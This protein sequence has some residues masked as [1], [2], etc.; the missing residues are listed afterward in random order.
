MATKTSK[1]T[2]ASKA[3]SVS[4]K[5]SENEKMNEANSKPTTP[6]SVTKSVTKSVKKPVKKAAPKTTK[7]AAPKTTEN[8][9]KS[10]AEKTEVT[11][12]V[13]KAPVNS[14]TEKEAAKPAVK[15]STKTYTKIPENYVAEQ[16]VGKAKEIRGR[17]IVLEFNTET[18]R[19][20]MTVEDI[21]GKEHQIQIRKSIFFD[22]VM[23]YTGKT[24]N[25]PKFKA[26]D[27][28]VQ[29]AAINSALEVP[30][31]TPILFRTV[32]DKD[33]E[34]LFGIM[35]NKWRPVAAEDYVDVA[36]DKLKELGRKAE[37]EIIPSDGLHGGI[38]SITPEETHDVVKQ[39]A[40]FNF[41]L[42]NGR[43]GIT[44]SSKAIVLACTNQLTTDIHGKMKGLKIGSACR[45]SD[46]HA[47]KD[48]KFESLVEKV[49]ESMDDYYN[50]I[51]VAK[52]TEISEE[53]R[54]VILNYYYAK[55]YF[56]PKVFKLIQ[57]K[58]DD[59]EIEQMPGTMYGLAMVVSYVGTH[60]EK[61]KDGVQN[62]L[63]KIAGEIIVVSQDFEGYM[64]IISSVEMRE[65]EKV[66]EKE[67]EIETKKPAKK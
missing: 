33:G 7:K 24:I 51:D 5:T 55:H 10:E 35:R 60:S 11:K 40:F 54:K 8:V 48:I 59:K 45:I 38:I 67:I 20:S 49:V 64:K 2:T 56:S 13:K 28:N 57:N 26:D 6:K 3:K 42:W 27:K 61:M 66:E 25:Y 36:K 50:I 46:I 44:M 47:G 39:T 15:T 53:Q 1:P 58:L 41:G 23:Y 37:V 32:E 52:E 63:S 65:E 31:K 29:K 14:K 62:Q 12:P 34:Y 9:A 22:S 17:V 16:Q 4:K 30:Q 18:N 21:E 19:G 43:N